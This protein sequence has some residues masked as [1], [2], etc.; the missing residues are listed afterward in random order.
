[1]ST[2]VSW[3]IT[4]QTLWNEANFG[5][6]A[7]DTTIRSEMDFGPSKV[8]RRTTVGIDR[9]TGSIYLTTSQYSVF[10]TFFD[11]SLNGGVKTFYFNHPIT[12]AQ[13]VFRFIGAY[14]IT[15]LG[16]GQFLLNFTWEQIVQ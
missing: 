3:P 7:G 4:L 15:S 6:D 9:F 14:K 11:V 13:E 1:M 5:L 10:K 12:E 2:P 8:R 16:A